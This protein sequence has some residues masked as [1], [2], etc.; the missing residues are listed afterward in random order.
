MSEIVDTNVIVRFLVGDNRLQQAKARS[1][2]EEAEKGK[3]KLVIKPIVVAEAC[4]VLESFYKKT[5]LEIS[6]AFEVF[7]SQRWFRV[8]ERG[9]L[10]NLW[11]FYIKNLHFV[12]SFILSWS[13]INNASILSFDQRLLKK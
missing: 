8:D 10:L 11:Q 7:L 4:F 13:K 6:E 3:R 9:V 5:R 1:W 2:F 12:D